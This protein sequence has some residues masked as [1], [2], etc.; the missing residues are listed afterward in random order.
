MEVGTD[1]KEEGLVW[2][3]GGGK[4]KLDT[5]FITSYAP[6]EWGAPVAEPV[7][8]TEKDKAAVKARGEQAS[9]QWLSTKLRGWSLARICL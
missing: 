3:L 4:G 7:L 6:E 2:A 9:G 5:V 1:M 8:T